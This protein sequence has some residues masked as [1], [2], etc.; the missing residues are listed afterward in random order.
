MQEIFAAMKEKIV[1]RP[2]A[3]YPCF[4]KLEE[5]SVEKNTILQISYHHYTTFIGFFLDFYST[6]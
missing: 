5:H 3:S 1:F 2:R 4:C 6:L